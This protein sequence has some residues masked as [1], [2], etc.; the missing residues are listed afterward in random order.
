MVIVKRFVSVVVLVYLLLAVLFLLVPSVRLSISDMGSGTNKT[1]DFFHALAWIGVLVLG[2]QFVVEN[3]DSALLRRNVN[4]QDDK[5]NELKAKLY[6]NQQQA[7]APP[8]ILAAP[9]TR[10]PES[11]VPPTPLA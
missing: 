3:L 11:N 9:A 7:P 8:V 5:I 6:D 1:E 10:F 4:S 2:L